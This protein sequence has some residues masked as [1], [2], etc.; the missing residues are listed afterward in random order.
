MIGF[1]YVAAR[2]LT[3]HPKDGFADRLQRFSSLPPCYPS[4]KALTLALM[5][6]IPLNMSAFVNVPGSS[7]AALTLLD[8][9]FLAAQRAFII[10]DNFFRMAALIGLRAVDFL[11]TGVAFLPPGFPFCFAHR[12]R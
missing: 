7:Q 8:A 10:A 11:E 2:G 12:A 1:T 6:L 5:G 4:Y 9:L 3:P